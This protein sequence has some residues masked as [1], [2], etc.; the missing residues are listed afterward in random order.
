MTFTIG[1]IKDSELETTPKRVA[2]YKG[3]KKMENLTKKQYFKLIEIVDI[4]QGKL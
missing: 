1:F 3:D 4:L 2:D